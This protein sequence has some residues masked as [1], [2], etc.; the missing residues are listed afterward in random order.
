MIRHFSHDDQSDTDQSVYERRQ[1][2]EENPAPGTMA[3]Y[4]AQQDDE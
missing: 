3:A 2:A 4:R 1:Q